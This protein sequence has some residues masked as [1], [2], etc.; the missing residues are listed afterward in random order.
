MI[1]KR[2]VCLLEYFDRRLSWLF[3]YQGSNVRGSFGTAHSV[4]SY[5]QI[6]SVSTFRISPECAS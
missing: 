3:S 4:E 5:Q 2:F 1:I 6:L